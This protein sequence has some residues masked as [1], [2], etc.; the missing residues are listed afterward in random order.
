MLARPRESV[1][2]F[3]SRRFRV[4]APADGSRPRSNKLGERVRFPSG[5]SQPP[6]C[7]RTAHEFPKL[8]IRDRRPVE[9]PSSVGA[10]VARGLARVERGVR[11]PYAA[12]ES[13]WCN[14][15]HTSL[16]SWRSEFD[17]RSGRQG[18]WC[19]GNMLNSKPNAPGST[20]GV[21][22]G[23][24]STVGQYARLSIG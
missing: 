23:R 22:R 12:H 21:P 9:A 10:V 11:F 16:R 4:H 2:G 20:P 3:E 19:N 15:Q 14:G 5:V 13:G 1:C 8:E 6:W 17:S 18:T 7:N 24:V